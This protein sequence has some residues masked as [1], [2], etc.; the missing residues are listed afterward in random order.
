M[1]RAAG[2]AAGLGG[3]KPGSGVSAW[4]ALLTE[5]VITLVLMIVVMA[6]AV[7]E[8]APGHRLAPGLAISFWVGA[9][10]FLA[11]PVSGA[12]LNPARTL[13]PDIVAGAFPSWW[14]YIV[15]PIVGAVLG[16]ALWQFVQSRGDKDVVGAVGDTAEKPAE[17][18]P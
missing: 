5:I 7:F 16:A 9:A 4:M 1:F 11:I 3:T 14:I 6:T 2:R 13:G 12:S 18:S 8:R 10:V 15:G 17:P